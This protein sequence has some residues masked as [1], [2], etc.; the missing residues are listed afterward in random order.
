MPVNSGTLGTT[1]S[2]SD[3]QAA[4]GGSHPISISEYYS[5]GANV[6]ST[7]TVVDSESASGTGDNTT[8]NVV[9]D[10]TTNPGSTMY[11]SLVETSPPGGSGTA[12]GNTLS[13]VT[14]RTQGRGNHSI[15]RYPQLNQGGHPTSIFQYQQD[16]NPGF[17]VTIRGGAHQSGD[18]PNSFFASI[19]SGQS[20]GW[21]GFSTTQGTLGTR[22]VSV[23]ATTYDHDITNNTGH[24]LNMT[25]SPWA[26]DSSFTDDETASDDGNSSASWSWSHPAVTQNANTNIPSSGVTSIDQFN[27]PGTFAG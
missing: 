15:V 3:L 17:N 22:T 8:G 26:D 16:D 19:G 20:I 23:S 27:V 11:G 12:N 18:G 1:I 7:N 9:V 24:T 10:V 4:Y 13:Y 25:M 21:S 6:P 2:W 5:G 14:L